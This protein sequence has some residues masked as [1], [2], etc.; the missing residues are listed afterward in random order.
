[1]KKIKVDNKSLR[2][3]IKERCVEA[4]NN[5]IYIIELRDLDMS[6]V[7]DMSDLFSEMD[8][9]I[10]RENDLEDIQKLK[11]VQGIKKVLKQKEK[12]LKNT[13]NESLREIIKERYK[14]CL[15]NK[16]YVIDVSDLDTSQVTDMTGLFFQMKE[17]KEIEGLKLW[18]TSQV[19]K[20]YD[21]FNGCE[22]LRTL[23]LST[24][25]TNQVTYMDFM[26]KNCYYLEELDVSSFDTS[27]VTD[28]KFMFG[29]CVSLRKLDL[30]G[31]DTS[32]VTNMLGMFSYCPKLK[33][34]DVSN[35]NTSQVTNMNLMFYLCEKLEE[36]DLSKWSM[37]NVESID[38]MLQYC[39]SLNKIN[40]YEKILTSKAYKNLSKEEQKAVFKDTKIDVEKELKKLN[41]KEKER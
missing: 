20:M 5:E 3:I 32:Q 11:L 28:M 23:D 12:E 38:F 24:W 25:K 40:G 27:K 35:F 17:L 31:W 8:A 30:S 4:I 22:N 19:T 9:Y 39:Y 34:I 36:L 37:K 15:D 10:K 14:E 18:D 41:K 21:M 6:R 13:D 7:T 33:S 26:F 2:E 1:M 29:D 16:T